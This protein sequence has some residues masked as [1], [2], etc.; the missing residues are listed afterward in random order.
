[1]FSLS[2]VSLFSPKVRNVDPIFFIRF[3]I[4]TDHPRSNCPIISAVIISPAWNTSQP[5]QTLTSHRAPDTLHVLPC[6][7]C[8]V[9]HHLVGSPGWHPLHS[10]HGTPAPL[11]SLLC[12]LKT[13]VFRY[14]WRINERKGMDKEEE[15]WHILTNCNYFFLFFYFILQFKCLFF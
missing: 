5:A 6:S 10:A 12:G 7:L 2:Y 1:V 14:E 4:M 11:S 13:D 8:V 3:I 9:W 15:S